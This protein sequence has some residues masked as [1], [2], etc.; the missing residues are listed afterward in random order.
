MTSHDMM[1]VLNVQMLMSLYSE[2]SVVTVAGK[3]YCGRDQIC[4]QIRALGD[5]E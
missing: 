5:H 3:E 4:A 2:S 1:C